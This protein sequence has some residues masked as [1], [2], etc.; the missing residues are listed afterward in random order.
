MK[1]TVLKKYAAL[2]ARM[3]VNIQKG[4]D[5]F[6]HAQP[7]QPEFIY[8]LTEECYKAGAANVFVEFSFEPLTKLHLKYRRESDLSKVMPW[9]LEKLKF[10]AEKLPCMIY[11]LSEDPDGLKGADQ[12]KLSRAS[13]KRYPVIKPFRDAMENRY[14][15]CIAAVPGEKWAKKLFPE[16][17]TSAAVEKLWEAILDASRALGEPIENW[18]AHNSFI[19]DRCSKLNSM[20]IAALHITSSNGTDIKIGF[21][22][23]ARFCG[24][25]EPT[26]SGVCFNANI[27]SEETYVTPDRS[28]TCGK[29][30]STM[31]LSYRGQLINDFWIRFEKGKAVEWDAKTN[32]ELLDEMIGMDEGSAYLGEC[33]LVPYNSPISLSGLLYYNTLFDEN[34]SC[35]LALGEG[36]SNCIDGYDKMEKA[37][38]K[39]IG[40]NE[41]MIHV[42]FMFGTEDLKIE[43]E[44]FDS[45]KVLIFN[46]GN[47]AF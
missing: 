2:I 21:N 16:L 18:K 5:V 23:K 40:V 41:S 37:D 44:C 33:A 4:Q 12:E 26:V 13:Q 27:P 38:L 35:H 43:A 29:I 3:G 39:K 42:D 8:I 28:K 31:P 6:I 24:G 46:N 19:S 1:K 25:S 11:I 14:Q 34:A 30:V 47:W 9:E 45:K 17:R 20:G 10:R 32:K 22:E 15:W 36:Y 7:D